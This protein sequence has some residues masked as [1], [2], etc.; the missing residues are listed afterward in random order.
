MLAQAK[1]AIKFL[2]R[3]MNL[4]LPEN[5]HI[6]SVVTG[7]GL[8]TNAA[9]EF[10]VIALENAILMDKKQQDYGSRNISD[11]GLVGVIIRMNDKFQ[12]IKNLVG[13]RRK[14]SVNESIRDT[15]R[16]ISNYAIIALLLDSKR[17]PDE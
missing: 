17:W 8:Q 16:D 1:S 14:A 7:L 4:K 12:R 3:T 2:N 6:E 15:F 10:L 9:K 13:N 11:F 5:F